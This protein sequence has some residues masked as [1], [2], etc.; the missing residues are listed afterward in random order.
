MKLTNLPND[1]LERIKQLTGSEYSVF[2]D[3][4]NQSPPVSVRLHPKKKNS[5]F[6]KEENV[7][8]CEEGRYLI[9]RPSFTFD[10]HFHAGCYYVQEAS[11]MMLERVWN[12]IM[13][14]VVSVRVLDMCAA[15]GGKSTHLLSL[16]N[17]N[18]YLI[19][20]E[21]I[22]NRN[23]VLQ[24]NIVK[25]GYSNCMVTQNKPEDF[26]ALDGFFD[27]VLVDAP[28]SGEGLFR[29][30]KDA[31]GEWSVQNVA[32]C[33]IRQKEILKHAVACLKPGGF[34][35]YCTCTY[36]PDEN[37]GSVASLPMNLIRLNKTTEGL[38]Q[39]K[40]GYQAYP[41]RVKGE[42]FYFSVMQKDGVFE[43]SEKFNTIGSTLEKHIL[44]T[45]PWLKSS[46]QYRELKRNELQFALPEGMINDYNLLKSQLYIRHAGIFLGETKGKDFIPSHDLALSI[47]IKQ[48]LPSIEL[49]YE[50]AILYLRGGTP[51][52]E[53]NYRGW[54]L[55]RY[56][57]KNLGW[58]K[59]MENRLNNYYPKNSRILKQI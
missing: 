51:R 45:E 48:D 17:G 49:N 42:G 8:W 57:S 47:E 14:S 19:A 4:L 43:P 30:D 39:T 5:L 3:E 40:F 55:V 41:H 23:K 34:L 26:S 10:P 2:I 9:Q 35:I 21:T 36:E 59:I 32:M 50:D 58:I 7:P 12:E 44:Y 54:C 33:A 27:V 1:F 53:T 46:K 56:E 24:Q 11:S 13:P 28:C 25:W 52:L 6:D 20:N 38:M 31:I 15:P 37:D 22:P 29:K 16:L 18:G